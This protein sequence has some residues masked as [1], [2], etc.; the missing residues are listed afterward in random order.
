M[1]KLLYLEASPRHENSYTSRIAAAFLETYQE[2]NPQDE[3]D[4]FHLFD[5]PVPEFDEEAA[6]MAEEFGFELE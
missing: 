5:H 1:A 3:I 6:R 2:L 4:H